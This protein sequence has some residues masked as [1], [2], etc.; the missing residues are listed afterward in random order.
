MKIE[1]MCQISNV[2]HR[3]R[4]EVLYT[5]L[6][7]LRDL[8]TKTFNISYTTKKQLALISLA[9]AHYNFGVPILCNS[10]AP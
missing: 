10:N 1:F 8:L 9:M 3:Q 4:I 7:D 6:F 5:N 2:M